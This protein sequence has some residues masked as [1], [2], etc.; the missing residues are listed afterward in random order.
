MT[1]RRVLLYGATGNS[2]RRLA[3]R[4]C[5]AGCD[6]VVAARDADRLAPLAQSL[7]APSRV[8]GLDPG[9]PIDEALADVA[10]VLHAAGP[11]RDT[12]SAMMA[13]CVRTKTHYL[14]IAGE[15]PVFLDAMRR[16]PAA[17]AADVMLMPGVGFSIVASDCLLALAAARAPGAKAFRL[18]I[19]WP[20]SMARASILTSLALAGSEVVVRRGG[21]LR[22][23]P[24]RGSTRAIDFG[25]G[26]EPVV[27]VS[28]PDV[29]T[30]QFT[31][32][33]PDIETFTQAD[34]LVRAGFAAGARASAWTGGATRRAMSKA[35]E[36]AWPERVPSRPAP[37]GDR[38]DDGR[39]A[40]RGVQDGFV[41]VVEAIDAWR[42]CASL[43]LAT[44]DGHEVT[45]ET[46]SAIV[47]KV[48]DG[49]WESGFRTPASLFGGEFIL[50]L[51]GT[52]LSLNP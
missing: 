23:E 39:R 41:L 37:F 12:A 42:R 9:E 2:G 36:W 19:S 45:T 16:S 6:I 7:R 52:L 46:A 25:H 15:W 11:F 26:P 27:P 31:T 24:Y 35:V 50:A 8:F 3:A 5:E 32:G 14:D 33:A 1:S 34:W 22:L 51:G 47:L 28:W 38:P 30:A 17:A 10:V 29:V 21:A 13:A 4:L 18:A 20:D 40:G 43:R 48:L 44:G 49:H